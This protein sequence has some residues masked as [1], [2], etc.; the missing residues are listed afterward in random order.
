MKLDNAALRAENSIIKRQ[1]SYF[2][3]LFATKNMHQYE[4]HSKVQTGTNTQSHASSISGHS[5]FQDSEN[6]LD[7]TTSEVSFVLERNVNGSS[8]ARR[9]GMFSL[10]LIMCICCCSQIFDGSGAQAPDGRRLAH[11]PQ[12]AVDA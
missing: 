12:V 3:N 4:S 11:G 2:E 1:L 8:T 6:Q 5:V 10:A 7:Q 9:L